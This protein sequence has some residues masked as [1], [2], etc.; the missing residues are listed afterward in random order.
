MSNET[1]VRAVN[2]EQNGSNS[3]GGVES[4]STADNTDALPAWVEEHNVPAERLAASRRREEILFGEHIAWNDGHEDAYD[5]RPVRGPRAIKYFGCSMFDM[6][7]GIEEVCTLV[8]EGLLDL[9]SRQ[10]RSPSV[11]ELLAIAGQ[12][13]QYEWITAS[14]GGY[15]VGPGRE[16]CRV[17]LTSIAITHEEVPIVDEAD[18]VTEGSGDVMIDHGLSEHIAEGFREDCIEYTRGGK[19]R[20]PDNME[21]ITLDAETAAKF[22]HEWSDDK[23]AVSAWW[24]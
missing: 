1:Q 21:T 18:R 22:G 2:D 15:I 7:V 8:A 19:R 4:E 14:F 11:A 23:R 10:N 9:T 24:D 6:R 17:S 16:D 12:A 5:M 3:D 13:E 20:E